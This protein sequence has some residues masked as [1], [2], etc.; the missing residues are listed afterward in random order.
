MFGWVVLD[1]RGVI[2]CGCRGTGVEDLARMVMIGGWWTIGMVEVLGRLVMKEKG[3]CGK[4]M[5]SRVM[6]ERWRGGKVF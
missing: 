2:R 5:V 1:E 3:V 4:D 6:D